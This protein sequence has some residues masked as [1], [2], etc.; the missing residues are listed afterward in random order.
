MSGSMLVLGYINPRTSYVLKAAKP[1]RYTLE[2]SMNHARQHLEISS[3]KVTCALKMIDEVI[4]NVHC[5][6]LPVALDQQD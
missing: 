1:N 5:R 4:K 3:A 2:G 6:W